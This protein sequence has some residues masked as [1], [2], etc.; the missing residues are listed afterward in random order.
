M[1]A[2]ALAERPRYA[3]LTPAELEQALRDLPGWHGDTR[4]ISRTV[5]PRDL[6][7]LLERVAEAEA[8]LDHHTLVDLDAGTVTFVTWTHVKDAVTPADL[9]LARCIDSVVEGG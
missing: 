2:S 8:A 7:G 4:R 3:A 9:E 6:W 1:V 5:R